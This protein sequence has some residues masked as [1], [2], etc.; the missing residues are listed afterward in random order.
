M[1]VRYARY[2]HLPDFAERIE[3]T[4]RFAGCFC[5]AVHLEGKA[6]VTAD[7]GSRN[8]SFAVSVVEQL[9][10]VKPH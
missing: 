6:T 8:S 3:L 9:F 7:V 1:N 2:R 4:E 10:Y 5:A